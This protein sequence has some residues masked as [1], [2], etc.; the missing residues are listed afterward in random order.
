[1]ISRRQFLLG[2][3]AGLIAPKFFDRAL[4]LFDN[5]GEALLEYSGVRGATLIASRDFSDNFTFY[6][7]DP[8][9]EP[10]RMTL[11]E[12]LYR[13]HA[14]PYEEA[15]AE[16]SDSG[17]EEGDEMPFDIICDAWCRRDSPN[18]KAFELLNSLDLTNSL[19]GDGTPVGEIH[20]INGP[21]PGNDYLAVE[22]PTELDLSLLQNRL[23]ATNSGV[24]IETG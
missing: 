4:A 24:Y 23:N 2:S 19:S 13:Y 14:L 6:W 7:G 18:A 9:T 22:C 1:M 8:K 16:W 5:Y 3:S 11:E 15:L 21:C 20:F 12:Y 10:P 17:Y